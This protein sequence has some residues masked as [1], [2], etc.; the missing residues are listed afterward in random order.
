MGPREK[1]TRGDLRHAR[2]PHHGC[3]SQSRPPPPAGE[4]REGRRGDAGSGRTSSCGWSP[5][6]STSSRP[7]TCAG[8]SRHTPASSGPTRTLSY[9]SSTVASARVASRPPRSSPSSG[10]RQNKAASG[11]RLNSWGVAAIFAFLVIV[12]CS[13]CSVSIQGEEGEPTSDRAGGV[14]GGVEPR[15]TGRNPDADVRRRRPVSDTDARWRGDRVHR[16]DR[17]RDRRG[18]RRLLGARVRDGVEVNPAGETI[19]VG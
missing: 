13:A 6:S 9:R 1:M 3:V 4:P 8:S 18:D 16:R 14:A 19:A 7:P 17:A 5:T 10:T 12:G 11:P 15:R 2:T